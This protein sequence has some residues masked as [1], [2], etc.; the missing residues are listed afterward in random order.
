M[1]FDDISLTKLPAYL[2]TEE[3]PVIQHTAESAKETSW[4]LELVDCLLEAKSVAK[5][6]TDYISTISAFLLKLCK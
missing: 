6:D 3:N 5:Y 1:K 4:F 2:A